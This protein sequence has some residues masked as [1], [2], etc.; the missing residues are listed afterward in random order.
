MEFE[1]EFS[2]V[3][4][5]PLLPADLAERYHI[6]SCLKHNDQKQIYLIADNNEENKYIMKCAYGSLASLLKKECSIL[7]I[8]GS[9]I[10]CPKIIEFAQMPDRSY[11]IREYIDGETIFDI[12]GKRKLT[13]KEAFDITKKVCASLQKLHS[14]E[15][16]IIVRDIKPEN[17]VISNDECVIIDFDAAREWNQ[18]GSSD[19]MYL[20]T[21]TTAAPEQFG[22]SQT[23]VRTDI[24]A[25]GMLMTYLLTGGYDIS[26]I[27]QKNAKR[28]V[29]KCTQFSPDKRYKNVSAVYKAMKLGRSPYIYIYIGGSW[30]GY[31][32]YKHINSEQNQR[33]CYIV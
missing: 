9:V 2:K 13:E 20:G 10:S 17:I 33:I 16:P 11:L 4:I 32:C 14:L 5:Q 12:V 31:S 18:D 19:T 22:Y 27:K 24:Y 8:A 30:S 29:E 3:Y 6:I 28:I 23:D 15:P 7:K 1:K 21:R 26:E 25:L